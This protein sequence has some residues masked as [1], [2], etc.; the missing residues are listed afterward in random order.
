MDATAPLVQMMKIQLEDWSAVRPNW[1]ATAM[2]SGTAPKAYQTKAVTPA[3][4][5]AELMSR[6]MVPSLVNIPKILARQ[7]CCIMGLETHRPN[8]PKEHPPC[9]LLT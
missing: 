6:V 8:K 1:L 2:C 5:A 7:A 4:I 3:H 9:R